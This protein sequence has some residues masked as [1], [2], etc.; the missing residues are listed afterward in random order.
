MSIVEKLKKRAAE[1][2]AKKQA[3]KA[4]ATYREIFNAWERED[5][6]NVEVSLYNR[7][8]DLMLREGQVGDA[9]SSWE[10][11]VDLYAD[12]GFHNH[13][14]ALCNKILRNAPGRTSV[15]YTLGKIS[16]QKGFRGDAKKNFLE[17][18]DRKQQS[19]EI[20]E[21]FRALKEFADL[22]PDE[23][24]IRQMLADQ[25]AK[26]GRIDEAVEQLQL[27]YDRYETAG[28]SAEAAATV[29]RMKAIDPTV[30][31][32]RTGPRRSAETQGLVFID[33]DDPT[34][35]RSSAMAAPARV[36]EPVPAAPPA[37]IPLLELH[38]PEEPVVVRD[39]LEADNDFVSLSDWLRD[40]A[41]SKSTRMVVDEDAPS[42][43]EDAYVKDLP[44]KFTPGVA[45]NV[46]QED[47]ESHYHLGVA[48]KAMGLIDEAIAELQKALRG[49]SQRVRT[50]EALGQCFAERGQVQ[51]AMTILQRALVEPGAGDDQLVGVLYLLGNG[52]EDLGRPAEAISYYQRVFAVDITFRDV[53][54]R[55]QR[56]EQAS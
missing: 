28:A 55:M 27:L 37:E 36:Q 18:A 45:E 11:A 25:L 50:F 47:H 8:G 39:G 35:R 21:A 9:V 34:P 46:E 7:A 29:E 6:G 3:D 41:G 38:E 30:E 16:A 10:R 19:N 54:D 26:L 23:D 32:R 40:E 1:F 52:A 31:P 53:A 4:I 20:D 5:L 43:D 12:G 44:R 14:I 24:D 17:Y 13:A 51:V 42:G 49:T 33:L 56:L 48:F 2:E 15:Y 22:C